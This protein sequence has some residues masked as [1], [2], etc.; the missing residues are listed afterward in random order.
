MTGEESINYGKIV[1]KCWSE[2]DFKE[3]FMRNPAEVLKNYGIS[4]DEGV[5]YNIISAPKFVQYAVLPYDKPI[6]GV[7]QLSKLML[8]KAERSQQLIPLC[9]ELRII[10]DTE[11]IRH[12]VIPFDPHLL[13]ES[14]LGICD[15]QSVTNVEVAALA[16][17]VTLAA[18]ATNVAAVTDAV[19]AVIIAIGVV[20]I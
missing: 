12:L 17:A 3:Y 15:V 11:H 4:T 2:P 5:T 10:Q 6:E 16:V 1:S 8:W 20:L 19:A 9:A 13:T 18:A 7:Q 14:D